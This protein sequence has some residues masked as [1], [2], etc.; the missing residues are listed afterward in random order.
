VAKE[1]EVCRELAVGI[2]ALCSDRRPLYKFDNRN[3][4]CGDC[5]AVYHKDC[6][7]ANGRCVKPHVSK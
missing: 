3:T 1:C 7:S 5:G 6:F 4:I 2:C